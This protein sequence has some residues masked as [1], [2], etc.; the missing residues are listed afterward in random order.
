MSR[1]NGRKPNINAVDAEVRTWVLTIAEDG[2]PVVK[3]FETEAEAVE[4]SR[5][6]RAN[7]RLSKQ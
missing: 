7:R 5:M 3:Q 4:F 2:H 6:K 1:R